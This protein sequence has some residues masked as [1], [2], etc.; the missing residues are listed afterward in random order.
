MARRRHR[1]S[2]Q[3]SRAGEAYFPSSSRPAAPTGLYRAERRR[4]DD[5]APLRTS[6]AYAEAY[7]RAVELRALMARPREP[8]RVLQPLRSLQAS[9]IRPASWA[10]AEHAAVSPFGALRSLRVA[11]PSRVWF[12]FKRKVRREVMFA[13]RSIGR[14][15]SSPGKRR[16]DGRM[17]RRTQDSQYG[18]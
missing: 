16:P 5:Y 3:F 4:L 14:A 12:C 18:C 9:L 10:N 6:G 1:F 7:R 2:S 15:G 11:T 8:V 13:L 17:Y